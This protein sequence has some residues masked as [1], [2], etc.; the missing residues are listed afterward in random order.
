MA[1]DALH[2]FGYIHR[3]VKPDN[4]LLDA[5]GHLKVGLSISAS[6]ALHPVRLFS[7]CSQTGAPLTPLSLHR[8]QLA[9]FGTCVKMDAQGLVQSPGA[10]VGTPDYIS[11][12]VLESQDGNGIY[13]KECDWW[14]TGIF[15]YE[16][17][18]GCVWK[19]EGNRHK[20]NSSRFVFSP[21]LFLTLLQGHPLLR[22]VAARVLR[23]NHEPQARGS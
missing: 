16:L 10:A 14:S 11:P 5:C 22:R 18:C 17:L 2:K 3:D 19:V 9:D 8:H 12:E 6:L 21:I 23:Q 15:L 7:L 1:L 20:G 4:L 13:G